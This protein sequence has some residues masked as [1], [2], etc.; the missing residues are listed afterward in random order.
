MDCG[1]YIVLAPERADC[2]AAAT[3]AELFPMTKTPV[4]VVWANKTTLVQIK[5][6]EV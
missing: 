3:A 4:L 1:R 5:N 6:K 2:M